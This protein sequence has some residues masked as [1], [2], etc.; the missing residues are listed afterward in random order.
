MSIKTKDL[1]LGNIDLLD[2]KHAANSAASVPVLDTSGKLPLDQMPNHNHSSANITT[3]SGYVK[4][5]DTSAIAST[6]TLNKAIGKLESKVDNHNHTSLSGVTNISFATASSDGAHIKTTISGTATYL[7]MYLQDDATEDKFRWRFKPY[8]S[9]NTGLGVEKSIMELGMTSAAD[10]AAKLDVKGVIFTKGQEVYHPGNK[11]TPADIGAVD[12][13]GT[14]VANRVAIFSDT[15]GNIKD[16]GFTIGKSVPSNAVFT[17]TNTWKANSSSSEGYVASGAGQSN[18]VWKTDANGN[19]GWRDDANTTYSAE[20]GIQLSSGKFGHANSVTAGT[21]QGSASATLSW[22]GTFTIPTVTYDSHGHITN[23]GT[24]TMTMPANP[25]TWRGVQNNLTSTAT[26]QSLAAAQGK[27]LK[28]AID[29]K[30]SIKSR[31]NVACETGVAGRPAVDGLSMSQAYNNGYPT[32][33]GNIINLKGRGDGQIL[34]GWSGTDGAHAPVYVRSK[35]DNTTTADWSGWAQLYSTAYKPTP[36]EIGAVDSTGTIVANR[37]A[38]FSDTNGNIKDSGFTI[39]KS[40]PSNAVFTDTNTWKAN[41]SSSEGYVASGSGHVNKVWKTDSNGNPAWREEATLTRGSYLT[42]SNYNGNSATTWAVDATASN[43]ANKVVARDSNGNFAAGTITSNSTV[44]NEIVVNASRA[45]DTTYT[46]SSAF[47]DTA[48]IKRSMIRFNAASG[49]N[50]P[51][52]IYLETSSTTADINKGVLHLCPSDDVSNDGTDYVTIHG[53]NDPEN[54]KFHTGGYIETVSTIQASTFRSTVG[55]GT[56][57]F[58]VS[59]NTVVTHLNADLLDGLNATSFMRSDAANSNLRLASGDG[60]GVRFWDSD[61]Y[62]I[63]MSGATNGTYGGRI[64][65]DTV[66]DYNMYFK[67][68]GTNRGFTF[69]TDRGNVAGITYEGDI[70]ARGHV[71][72]GENKVQMKYNSSTESLDFIF[73]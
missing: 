26:D 35:R 60:N 71:S 36:S 28:E 42:G 37:V 65:G 22:G 31:G 61:S 13:L 11:P 1:I 66:S 54:I 43:T 40:V 69:K 38:V 67:M 39:G 72:I 5:T 55:Q 49:S 63:Y 62:K 20:K 50:D 30:N 48:G 27:V 47:G 6:D 21:A 3:M 32:T 10:D 16:S 33:C 52:A 64:A 73:A 56:A 17:D 4:G 41:T 46:K 57:P 18:K 12:S 51:G 8:D 53:T 14:I 29:N 45:Y 70:K 15:N 34:V 68:S 23:K 19:P 24:T 58:T 25:N 2:G 59:S 7:D 44:T 9:S